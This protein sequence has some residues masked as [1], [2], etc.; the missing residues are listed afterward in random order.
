MVGQAQLELGVECARDGPHD[1][2]DPS[3]NLLVG[4]ATAPQ[5]RTKV[6]PDPTEEELLASLARIHGPG[7]TG[8]SLRAYMAW[9]EP[10][11]RMHRRYLYTAEAPFGGVKASGIGRDGGD[12]SF[13]FYMETKN[14]SIATGAHNIQKLGG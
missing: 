10:D 13:D 7:V 5:F 3:R 12:W 14:V 11:A 9:F 2:G 6:N 1:F 8:E 4:V